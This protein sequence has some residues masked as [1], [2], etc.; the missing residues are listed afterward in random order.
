VQYRVEDGYEK[1]ALNQK[2]FVLGLVYKWR[3]L[4]EFFQKTRASSKMFSKSLCGL[5]KVN[6]MILSKFD[7]VMQF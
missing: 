2:S 6:H 4:E 7:V 5:F 1:F 3:N